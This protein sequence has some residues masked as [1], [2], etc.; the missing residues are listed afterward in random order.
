MQKLES[1]DKNNIISL[2]NN[3]ADIRYQQ[4]ISGM[5]DSFLNILVPNML[6]LLSP[7]KYQ[8]LLDVGCG[9]GLFT[10]E[11]IPYS[12]RIFGID[13]SE[14][15]I[16]IAKDNLRKASNIDYYI[17]D[18]EF[19]DNGIKYDCIT[20]N[21]VLMDV[22]NVEL[23]VSNI[24]KLLGETGEF[25]FSITHPCYWPIY[26]NYYKE[27]WFDYNKELIIENNFRIGNTT[28]EQKTIHF[29]RPLELY[30]NILQKNSLNIEVMKELKGKN[31]NLPR[32]L[33]IKCR[34]GESNGQTNSS[35]NL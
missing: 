35:I 27:D 22:M 16:K 23:I 30:F 3:I 4:I 15:N 32:F 11:L 14:R 29:H 10:K 1:I 6:I 24:S 25:V 18:A 19:F 7:G 9:N 26:W 21:M 12:K 8:N 17:S 2:W 5:D 20:S 34:K 13:F 28:V 31:F 33:L